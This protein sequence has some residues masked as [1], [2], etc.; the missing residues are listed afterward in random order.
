MVRPTKWPA[1]IRTYAVAQL[2]TNSWENV[3]THIKALFKCPSP[4]K[5]TLYQW[6]SQASRGSF[7]SKTSFKDGR[8]CLISEAM[9]ERLHRAARALHNGFTFTEFEAYVRETLS[10]T[11][12]TDTLRRWL[13]RQDRWKL[14]KKKYR[15]ALTAAQRTARLNWCKS[16][17]HTDWSTVAFADEKSWSRLPNQPVPVYIRSHSEPPMTRITTNRFSLSMWGCITMENMYVCDVPGNMTWEKYKSILQSTLPPKHPSKGWR[18]IQD[19]APAHKNKGKGKHGSKGVIEDL[20][21][22]FSPLPPYSPDLNPIENIWGI[23]ARRIARRRSQIS[24]RD[25]LRA[26]I[27]KEV[28]RIQIDPNVLHNTISSMPKRIQQIIKRRGDFADC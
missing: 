2:K 1:S 24:S 16:H 6:K 14:V 27:Q 25:T 23:M 11:H 26:E 28:Q 9:S 3:S 8:K 4:A 13:Q 10:Y 17:L 7:P 15:W 18:F 5:S 22:V 20:G 21:F 19:N 12:S